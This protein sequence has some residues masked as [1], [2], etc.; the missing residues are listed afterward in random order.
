VIFRV[1]S[2]NSFVEFSGFGSIVLLCEGYH[3]HV[4]K[5]PYDVVA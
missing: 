3:H 5:D 2:V 1:L 4:E